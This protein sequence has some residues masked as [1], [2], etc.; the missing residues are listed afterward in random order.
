MKSVYTFAD[1]QAWE[2][3]TAGEKPPIRLAVI[4]D[5]VAHSAS[6]TMQNAALRACGIDTAYC[7][8]HIHP[9]ELSAALGLFPKKGFV[10]VNCTI[11]HKAAVLAALPE[12]DDHAIRAG[13]V[14]T[15][16]VGKDGRLQ[17]FSTDGLGLERAVTEQFGVD[18]RDQRVLVLGAGG[19]AGHAVARHCAATGVR[20][21]AL[22]NRTVDKLHAM[23]EAIAGIYPRES[24]SLHPWTDTALAKALEGSD[25]VVNCSSLGMKPDDPSPIP[26]ILISARH[27]IYD[28]IYTANHT[29][30]MRAAEQ[31]GARSAN[32][33]S[34]LLHQGAISFEMWFQREAPLEIMRKALLDYAASTGR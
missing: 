8:L 13:G 24:L 23:Q 25:L 31:A 6:P 20:H 21:L 14:N 5:P 7:R 19:G 1:L 33:L 18:L 16:R 9:N 28:T 22:V 4:G 17:G 3:V 32:G 30:L 27:L 12:V 15:I 10:G 29:P 11:P 2:T 26:A 34:M